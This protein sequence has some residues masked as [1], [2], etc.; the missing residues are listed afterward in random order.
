[1]MQLFPTPSAPT[2]AILTLSGFSPGGGLDPDEDT[3]ND[4]DD[5][6]AGVAPA[7]AAGCRD[8]ERG[9]FILKIIT[10]W[11]ANNNWLE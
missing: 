4:D 1:M 11:C 2:K 3:E 8:W 9:L 7:A 10:F 5:D 6:G